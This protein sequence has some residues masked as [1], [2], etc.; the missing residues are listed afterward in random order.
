MLAQD[1]LTVSIEQPIFILV[2]AE[3]TAEKDQKNTSAQL[4]AQIRALQIIKYNSS[5]ITC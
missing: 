3:R 2:E 1:G 4:P 5:V